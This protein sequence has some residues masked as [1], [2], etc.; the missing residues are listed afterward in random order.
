MQIGSYDE[1][2]RYLT[3]D[4]W[5]QGRHSFD[6]GPGDTLTA[7]ITALTPEEQ[8][9]ARW[10]LE[11]WTNVTGIEFRFVTGGADIVFD[12]EVGDT[13]AYGTGGPNRI[14]GGTILESGVH[15]AADLVE[16]RGAT[17]D[18]YSFLVFVHEIGHALHLGHPGAYPVDFVNPSATFPDDATFLNDSYQVSLMS[19]FDQNEN[20]HINASYA[21]PVTPMIVD[22]VAIQDLYGVPD[23]INAGDTVYGWGSNVGGYLGQ[24]FGAM[25][26]EQP[27]PDV[28]ASGPV[29][30][31]IYDNGGNDTLDLRWDP[32][33]QRVDLRPEGISDVL[34][35]TGN[36][37]IARDT[38]IENFVAG[39][40]DDAVTG[41]DAA[42][43][44]EGRGGNDTLTGGSGGDVLEGGDGL[45]HLVGGAGADQLDGGSGNDR[46]SHL[47]SNAGVRVDLSAGTAAMGHA[48][49]DTLINIEEIVG[50]PHADTLT[51]GEGSDWLSGGGG[52]DRLGG[53]RGRDVLTGGVGADTLD[54]GAGRDWLWYGASDAGVRVDLLTGKA[55]GGHAEGDTLTNIEE[56]VGS[57]HADTLTGGSG[58][59]W[60]SGR[61]GAD[62]LAGGAGHDHLT[63]GAGGDRMDGG[64][65]YD[66]LLYRGSDAGVSVDL[67]TGQA[68]GGDARDDT[69][70]NVEGISGSLYGDTLT[71]GDGDDWLSGRGG[72]D[73]L[74]GGAGGDRLEGGA[75]GDTASYQASHAAVQVH[76][77]GD[78][79][80][81]G[82]A[83]GDTFE[84]I[85]HLD[86]SGHGD[87]LIGDGGANRLAGNAG[88]DQLF[89]DGGDDTLEG[90]S[91][92]DSLD[93]GEGADVL[94]YAG[95]S[96]SV[97]ID[98][99]AGTAR[100]GHATGDTF[101]SVEGIIGSRHR[102]N[103]TG[104]AGDDTLTGGGG[105][106]RLD[107]GAGVDTVSYADSDEAVRVQLGHGTASGGHAE[108]DT[109][110]DI[111]VVVGSEH[112]DALWGSDSGDTL[113]GGGGD[114]WLAGANGS[115]VLIG[116]DGAD[117]LRGG[118]GADELNG[119]AGR[120]TVSYNTSDTGVRIDLSTGTGSGG[121]AEG[122]AI[123]NV[124]KASGSEHADT[125]VAGNDS[126][127]DPDFDYSFWGREGDD[128][129]IGGDGRDWLEGDDG[130]D[131]LTGGAGRDGL[132]GGPGADRIDGGEDD[133]TLWYNTS[134]AGVSVNLAAGTGS[135]GH[136]EG[137]A[138]Q[139]IERVNG[140]EHADMLVGGSGD[141]SF[142]GAGGDDTLDG[143]AGDDWLRGEGG[144]DVFRFDA[145]APHGTDYI[146]DFADRGSAGEQDLIE[147]VGGGL[148]FSSLVFTQQGSHVVITT[149]DAGGNVNITL[150]D[151]LVDHQMGDL[152]ADDFLFS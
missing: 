116:G 44:L 61:G 104:G 33:D 2:A 19:Y 96:G 57:P 26:G 108:G 147:I 150:R 124:E 141:E 127:V 71:G 73:W 122:D 113:D 62:V 118:A 40:G 109:F 51:G 8:Q 75:G 66:R 47:T 106:D 102:D 11:A 37:V 72:D 58:N 1:I 123:R 28:Y 50:S 46:A 105:A 60:L 115:D 30:L 65:G 89:G 120:D 64:A 15:I 27:D 23:S 12:H 85:E 143:G 129:L 17:I 20:T 43:R 10:A 80:S 63:G 94:S 21:N 29:A 121:H 133:D 48:E 117:R 125:L 83:E 95:S 126:T 7:D 59:D 88:D 149:G 92:G 81:G 16:D 69:F 107:G 119:G 53:G 52:D 142:L 25:S 54:G 135:G 31:T 74:A 55:A 148:S 22:I 151:Y 56:I 130:N 103:L 9:L 152:G 97:T 5:E 67:S 134:D 13:T 82:H 32:D 139:N 140:S 91:G 138:I 111:E 39:A 45:D 70:E 101:Q 42:N 36:I 137:D 76:L 35:L 128:T 146:A 131:V 14:Q 78:T 90:G 77:R 144:N 4:Y 3:D 136:A 79:I 49:G 41:N 132:R 6:A 84:A 68:R 34:G 86:G 114:D 38:V 145:D 93:G 18:S 112:A 87:T 98:L 100:G 110:Q 24:L 99:S